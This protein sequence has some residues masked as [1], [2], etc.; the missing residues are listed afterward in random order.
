MSFLSEPESVTFIDSSSLANQTA[1]SSSSP[2]SRQIAMATD[3]G[4]MTVSLASP[5]EYI[6][7][8]YPTLQV[9]WS[10][11]TQPVP[12]QS[13]VIVLPSSNITMATAPTATSTGLPTSIL[14]GQTLLNLLKPEYSK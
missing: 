3:S 12:A 14:S 2:A 5:Q 9:I 6:Q 7:S 4:L 8:D 10:Q 11:D 1:S 13:S